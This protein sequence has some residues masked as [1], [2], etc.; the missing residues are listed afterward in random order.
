MYNSVFYSSLSAT[1][2]VILYATEDFVNGAKPTF[3]G[4]D[5][6][7]VYWKDPVQIQNN[8]RSWDRL[9]NSECIQAYANDIPTEH[10]TL[11]IV[12]SNRSEEASSLLWLEFY[13]WA[14]SIPPTAAAIHYNPYYW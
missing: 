7:D 13:D 8:L 12:S 14:G 5:I 6:T 11:V 9:D 3:R 10:G 2:Y 4:E 1:S